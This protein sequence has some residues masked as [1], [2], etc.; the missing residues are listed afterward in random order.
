MNVGASSQL[1][2]DSI[3][4]IGPHYART[5]REWRGRFSEKFDSVIEPALRKEYPDIMAG[6]NGRFEIDVFRRK[7]ICKLSPQHMFAVAY[8]L[9]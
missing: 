7:W 8:N 2:I 4:N 1:T 9:N 3:S 6:E 5:L